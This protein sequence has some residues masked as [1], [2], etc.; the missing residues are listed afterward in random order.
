MLDG[1]ETDWFLNPSLEL[2]CQDYPHI[3][4]VKETDNPPQRPKL[5]YFARDSTG[6]QDMD[7]PHMSFCKNESELLCAYKDSGG[8]HVESVDYSLSGFEE[9]SIAVDD[10]GN[11]HIAYYDA[12][13]CALKYARTVGL[14]V[15]EDLVWP[16]HIDLVEMWPNPSSG[17]LYSRIADPS[18]LTRARFYLVDL[19]GRNV[20]ELYTSIPRD[21]SNS[22][23]T[24]RIPDTV[25]NGIY[26]LRVVNPE[27]SRMIPVTII[28]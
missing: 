11:V 16:L 17:I 2:D 26:L 6:W 4:Y 12:D 7:R 18:A 19:A 10:Y 5:H 27:T 13:G 15:M 23:V 24:F 20:A 8:W 21:R 22:S 14:P 9:T 28:R 3:A 1:S 25:M